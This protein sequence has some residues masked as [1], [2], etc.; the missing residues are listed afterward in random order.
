L[1]IRSGNV[2][3]RILYFF[4]QGRAVLSHG[5]SERRCSSAGRNRAGAQEQKSFLTGPSA[6]YL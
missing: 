5:C 3:Y 4:H 6:A 2:Q 1:R